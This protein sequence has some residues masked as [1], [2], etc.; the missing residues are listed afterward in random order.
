MDITSPEVNIY[1]VS[2]KCPFWP[3]SYIVAVNIIGRGKW[4]IKRKLSTFHKSLTNFLT[5]PHS[6]HLTIDMNQQTHNS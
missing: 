2:L 3:I 5:L 6:V 4:C 1:G